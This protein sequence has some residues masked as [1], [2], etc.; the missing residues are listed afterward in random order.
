MLTARVLKILATAGVA[1]FFTLVAVGNLTDYGANFAFVRHVLAMDTT[2]RSPALMW[3]AI[4]VP[5]V[6]H[7]LY[8]LIIIWQIATA[9]VCWVGAARMALRWDAPSAVFARAK[10]P[11]LAG[12]GM[13]FLLYAFG[14]VAIGGEWFAM[15][16]SK[17]WNGQPAAHLFLTVTGLV[18]LFLNQRDEELPYDI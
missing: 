2:F 16:Q 12:V 15:W 3:R 5:W 1:L 4:D 9:A 11:A 13:G 14:F 18:L 7:L 10:A 8:A 6:H 17:E